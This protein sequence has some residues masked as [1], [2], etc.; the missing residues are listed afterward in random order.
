MPG[1][2]VVIPRPIVEALLAT[3]EDGDRVAHRSVCNQVR[4][5]SENQRP[6]V[7]KTPRTEGKA[8]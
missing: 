4:E 6:D 1:E 5:L 3:E 8:I 7:W 2:G